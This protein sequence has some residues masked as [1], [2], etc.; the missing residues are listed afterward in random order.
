MHGMWKLK[1]IAV[2]IML[3]VSTLL[4]LNTSIEA[5]PGGNVTISNVSP[6]N[7]SIANEIVGNPP[8]N[9]GY[10]NLSFT[11][12]DANG[13]NDMEFYINVSVDGTWI[14]RLHLTSQDTG[15]WHQHE[16]EFCHT[17]STYYWNVSYRDGVEDFKTDLFH[18]RAEAKPDPPNTPIPAN[19][20]YH[21]Y[22]NITLSCVVH[23]P[24]GVSSPPMNVTFYEWPS[25]RVIG[26][27]TSSITDGNTA[28]CD[29]LYYCPDN[30]T[31]YYWY[32]VTKDDEFTGNNSDVWN[33]EIWYNDTEPDTLWHSLG[34]DIWVETAYTDTEPTAAWYTMGGKIITY[35]NATFNNPIPTDDATDQWLNLIL[36]IDVNTSTP[37]YMDF[38]IRPDGAGAYG[39]QH[40]ESGVATN[41]E[42]VDEVT[43]DD[44]TTYIYND[45]ESSY[46]F[47][48]YTLPNHTVFQHGDQ[49]NVTV[50]YRV[51]NNTRAECNASG[52]GT[53][54]AK[55]RTHDTNYSL[56]SKTLSN[57]WTDYNYTWGLNPYTSQ[58][59]TWEEVDNLQ[60]GIDMIAGKCTQLYINVYYRQ[61]IS[62]LTTQFY[63]NDTVDG[64]WVQLGSNIPEQRTNYTATMPLSGLQFNKDYWWR[65]RVFNI[66]T[67]QDQ[68]SSDYHFTTMSPPSEPNMLWYSLGGDIWVET[69]YTD[70]E[71]TTVWY[72]M[73]G[74]ITIYYMIS[75]TNESPSSGTTGLWRNLVLSAWAHKSGDPVHY[76]FTFYT[77]DTVDETW[78][79]MVTLTQQL[80]N[81]TVSMP[82]SG[83]EWNK[84]YWWKVIAVNETLGTNDSSDIWYFK[85]N[86]SIEE[87][88]TI[89]FS[90]GGDI[91]VETAYT[92]TEPST[93]WYTMGG[94]I[95]LGAPYKP[96][97]PNPPDG[98]EAG[99]HIYP[100][101]SCYVEDPQGYRMNV[102]FYWEDG[103]LIGI[104]TFVPSGS[105][106]SVPVGWLTNYTWYGWYAVANNSPDA[107]SLET[108]SDTWQYKPGN[109]VPT[110]NFTPWEG[111][112]YVPVRR[113]M[114]GGAY[115]YF[116]RLI[117]NI[118]DVESDVIEYNCYVDDPAIGNWNDWISRWHIFDASNGTY[119]HD[120]TLFDTPLTTYHWRMYLADTYNSSNHYMNFT[121][122]FYFWSN[123]NFTPYRASTEDN[124]L[125]IDQSV[126]ATD[127][128]WYVNGVLIANASGLNASDQFNVS[129]KINI[130]NVYNVTLVV[131]NESADI[132]D[133]M[134]RYIYIDR[135]LTLDRSDVSAVTYYGQSPKGDMNASELC[136][137]LGI[138]SNTWLHYY[139]ATESQWHSFWI[140]F[141]SITEDFNISLWDAFAIVIGEDL[142][143]RINITEDPDQRESFFSRVAA[144]ENTSNASQILVLPQ[145]YNY[146]CWSNITTTTSYNLS[147]GLVAAQDR[148]Y[149]Y[150]TQTGD[151]D[152]YWFGVS[153]QCFDIESYDVLILSL[154]ASKTITIGDGF[155]G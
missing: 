90:L 151:W 58:E 11:L 88:D 132:T 42:C 9:S 101:F 56:S 122:G 134:T 53:A 43:P 153:G 28:T 82:F 61:S 29:T 50:H 116:V 4:I 27:D 89:W 16:D 100:E 133:S 103:T 125:L 25:G 113:K 52:P 144:L 130:S 3:L 145:G 30:G 112:S 73:G 92:D 80:T 35:Y 119:Y 110:G 17:N 69:A 149:K 1:R 66:T 148:V 124:V 18:F 152:T 36:S 99:K 8:E 126:N 22:G 155:N 115:Q 91:W 67:E 143:K 37:K 75:F 59:W 111:A 34:G 64:T 150:N 117:W 47:D 96:I 142:S 20:S 131:Y 46:D 123:F 68:N 146:I 24:D 84:T 140:D 31:K 10:V 105:R 86:Y 102:S 40:N 70:T 85:T 137:L 98:R 136:S 104:D 97:N 93:V 78:V 141:P 94:N 14:N 44:L 6:V 62:E 21:I 83:L 65:V 121:T 39:V 120:E 139:N 87:P 55:I 107:D 23:H 45:N 51:K 108:R 147:I 79:P 33:I 76:D 128:W 2:I 127:Y 54:I 12:T 114:V 48:L 7:Q 77:N 63:I 60:A 81:L 13:G 109:Q 154:G 57:S 19:T 135:N 71:P 32:A 49:L 118:T 129:Y 95:T 41:W 5:G 106:A 26:Y 74:N 15:S 72:T 38:E 138:S